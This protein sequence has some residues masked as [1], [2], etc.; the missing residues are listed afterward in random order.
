MKKIS[1]LICNEASK[2]GL[3]YGFW[4]WFHFYEN[5]LQKL[6]IEFKFFNK[7]NNEFLDSDYLFLN[8]RYFKSQNG[9]V[10]L[11]EI[12]KIQNINTNLYW[13]DM[14]DSAGTTQF[15]VLPYVKKY[16]KKSYYKN[17]NLY[18][19]KM[20]GGRYYTDFYINK[21]QLKDTNEYQIKLLDK[22]YES[23]LIL[24]WNIGV[25]FF[26][27]YLENSSFDYYKELLNCKFSKKKLFSKKLNFQNNWNNDDKKTDVFCLM[28]K[29]FSRASVGFQRNLLQNKLS[30]LKNITITNNIRLNKR[31]YYKTLINSKVSTG[32]YG[33]GEVCYREFEAIRCGTAFMFPNMSNIDTWPNIYLDGVTYISYDLD[34]NN[35]EEKLNELVFNLKLRKELVSNSQEILQKTHTE[36]GK[37]Y[38]L[39]KVIEIIS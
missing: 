28:N 3:Y 4:N 36:L 38:F 19:I 16:I 12:K 32:A 2:L 20:S 13:F 37:N 8:S 31:K 34:F 22:R 24:G 33:W 10:E 11:S 23:K 39:N 14:R 5:E 17:K 6:G 1:I 21:Y 9:F 15:E 26:F 29:K 35:F 7:I 27:N 18:S 25:A 30:K